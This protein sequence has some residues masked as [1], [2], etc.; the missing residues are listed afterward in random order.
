[1][2]IDRRWVA[3][4]LLVAAMAFVVSG[5]SPGRREQEPPQ[6]PAPKGSTLEK[7]GLYRLPDDTALALGTLQYRDLEGGFWVVVE[8]LP[9]NAKPESKAVAVIANADSLGVDLKELEGRYVAAQGRMKDGLSIRIAGPEM[10]AESIEVVSK[11]P[12]LPDTGTVEP[13]SS[14]PAT[15]SPR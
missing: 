6:K 12:S 1:M 4:G 10:E 11:S 8:A 2:R 14:P 9:K 7:P 15:S 3:V 13:T 5:C